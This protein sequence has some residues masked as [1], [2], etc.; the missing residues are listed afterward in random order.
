MKLNHSQ[1]WLTFLIV[2]LLVSFNKVYG[3]RTAHYLSD[4]SGLDSVFPDRHIGSLPND[5]PTVILIFKSCCSPNIMA[6]RWA[7]SMHEEYGD[8]LNVI[9]VAIDSPRTASKARPWL[10]SLGV[11]FPC[12]WDANHNLIRSMGIKTTP[13]LFVIDKAGLEIYSSRFFSQYDINQMNQII[14][15]LFINKN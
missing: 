7:V 1:F 3:E 4:I 13:S 9:G 10:S 14:P 11:K 12:F 15:N 8:S 2:M 5:K 6:I